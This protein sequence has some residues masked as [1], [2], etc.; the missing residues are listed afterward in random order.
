[1]RTVP[2]T[3]RFCMDCGADPLV[4]AGPPGPAFA[5][6]LKIR[7]NAKKADEGA[8]RR[9]TPADHS[10]ARSEGVHPTAKGSGI[11]L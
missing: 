11:A 7:Q 1:M 5:S 9:G 6:R 8:P 4:R 3:F 10:V 2:P